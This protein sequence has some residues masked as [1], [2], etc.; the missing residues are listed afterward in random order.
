MNAAVNVH[1]ELR[2]LATDCH[3][4]ATQDQSVTPSIAAIDSRAFPSSRLF[5]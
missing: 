5:T 1:H 2:E 4:K 3:G